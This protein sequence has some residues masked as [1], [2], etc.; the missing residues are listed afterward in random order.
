MITGKAVHAKANLA[1]VWYISQSR[2][3]MISVFASSTTSL[4]IVDGVLKLCDGALAQHIN[5]RP[6]SIRRNALQQTQMH[7]DPFSIYFETGHG[8]LNSTQKVAV[9]QGWF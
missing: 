5:K 6:S 9:V 7:L 8:G 2:C 1:V 3:D 4:A